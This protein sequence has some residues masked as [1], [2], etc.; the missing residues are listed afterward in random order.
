M[1]SSP[2]QS[3]CHLSFCPA[4]ANSTPVNYAAALAF[5]IRKPSDGSEPTVRFNFK[6][7]TDDDTFRAYSMSLPGWENTQDVPLSAFIATMQP[8]AVNTT[9]QW[10]NTCGQTTE[11]GCAALLGAQGTT[12]SVS[13]SHDRISPVGAG[14]LGAGLAVAVMA[15]LL[16]LLMFTG[17]L[18]FGKKQRATSSQR[19]LQSSVRVNM[20]GS[21]ACVLMLLSQNNSVNTAE[22]HEASA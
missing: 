11:R 15:M 4:K 1:A 16:A 18:S 21:I 2:L 19:G 8:A 17:W 20:N 6:N 5:E 14:F 7:G 12:V 22:K 9:L 10:C 3:V 13:S